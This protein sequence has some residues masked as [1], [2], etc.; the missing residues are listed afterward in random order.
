MSHV[1]HIKVVTLNEALSFTELKIISE[2][3]RLHCIYIKTAILYHILYLIYSTFSMFHSIHVKRIILGA[4]IISIKF[5]LKKY[6]GHI[7]LI[8]VTISKK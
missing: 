6:R 1:G 2:C 7:P 4:K 3:V 8:I 5:K